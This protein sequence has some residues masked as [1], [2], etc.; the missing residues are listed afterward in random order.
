MLNIRFRPT[1]NK[2][3]KYMRVV[4]KY[5][6]FWICLRRL[7]ITSNYT[8]FYFLVDIINMVIN[9]NCELK[10][11]YKNF[12]PVVA[13]RFDKNPCSIE[14]DIRIIIKNLWDVRLK[15]RMEKYWAGSSEP[16]CKEFV[17]ILLDYVNDSWEYY[18]S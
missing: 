9:E 15:S 1:C 7:G 6:F 4:D 10:N 5:R 8:G 12:Y 3:E 11:M 16:R 2:E 14:R 18:A 13:K 17:K